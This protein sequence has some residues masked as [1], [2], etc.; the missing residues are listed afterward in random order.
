M[1]RDRTR[2]SITIG[3]MLDRSG[4]LADLR[5]ENT[6][7]A[8]ERIENLMELVSAARE[9]ESRETEATLG[10]FVDR[11]SLLSEA[12]EESGSRDAR[13]WLMTHARGEGARV[14]VV[15][16]AGMEDGL[17]PHSRASADEE[18]LEEERRLCY[19]GLTRAGSQLVLTGAA[20]RRVFGEY[21]G[22]AAIAVSRGDPVA[23]HRA[24]GAG[25]GVARAVPAAA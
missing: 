2:V 3:K 18:E 21:P 19:V 7:E 13:V 5:E 8:E 4:Y 12:D 10:G 22:H 24:P 23:A 20:R 11:L 6:E 1:R 16:M 14:P 17:F 9:Y 25:L 15:I